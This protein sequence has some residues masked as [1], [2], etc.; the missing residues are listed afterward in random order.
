MAIIKVSKFET[1]G[2]KFKKKWKNEKINKIKKK[3]ACILV[4]YIFND[5]S[6]K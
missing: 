3:N 1:D 6:Y 2:N 5:K 4:I